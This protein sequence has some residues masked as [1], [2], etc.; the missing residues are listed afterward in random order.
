MSY[1]NCEHGLCGSHLTR[2]LTHIVES[3][4]AAGMKELLLATCKKVSNRKGKK[5]GSKEYLDLQKQ[6]KSI[7]KAGNK[8]LP[9]IPAN[10]TGKRGKLAKSDAHNLWERLKKY[11]SS[12]L[13]FAKKAEVSFTNNRAIRY[14]T[15][16]CFRLLQHK[17]I[18]VNCRTW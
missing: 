8:E 9:P 4:E 18:V 17:H 13:L 2:E 12:V 6:Y 7:L 10:P 14:E 11:E 3:N 16:L 15:L 1:N 5:L